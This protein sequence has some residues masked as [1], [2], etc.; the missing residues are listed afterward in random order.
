MKEINET[1][2][3][4]KS[5]SRT[6]SIR[7]DLKKQGDMIFSEES[8]RVINEM[9]NM[10]LFELGQISKTTQCHSCLTHLPED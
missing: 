6:K 2:E 1:L 3:K 10:E 5:G 8:S 4:L 7:D 9:G